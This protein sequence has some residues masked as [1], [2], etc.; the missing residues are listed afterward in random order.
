[1]EL[2]K[3]C[4]L[5]DYKTKKVRGGSFT[6]KLYKQTFNQRTGTSFIEHNANS[7]KSSA[8]GMISILPEKVRAILNDLIAEFSKDQQVPFKPNSFIIWIC[9]AGCFLPLQVDETVKEIGDYSFLIPMGSDVTFHLGG[10]YKKEQDGL[11]T[12]V[13]MGKDFPLMSGDLRFFKASFW[14]HGWVKLKDAGVLNNLG[15]LKMTCSM[16]LCF[17][18]SHT[19]AHS[20]DPLQSLQILW[21]N[22][23]LISTL[24]HLKNN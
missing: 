16:S 11:S 22:V 24:M 9:F 8:R 17:F 19:L 13:K 5:W 21:L 3:Y 7:W 4:E 14:K 12:T 18:L 6:S 23:Y 2:L 20:L 15:M 10:S 1:M